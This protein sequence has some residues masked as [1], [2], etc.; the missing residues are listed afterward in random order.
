MPRQVS[1]RRSRDHDDWWCSESVQ[2]LV[3]TFVNYTI[4]QRIKS[5]AMK[6]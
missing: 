3:V 1:T 6:I 2:L 4:Y 5:I